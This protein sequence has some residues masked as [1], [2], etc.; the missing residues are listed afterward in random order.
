MPYKAASPQM[1]FGLLVLQRVKNQKLGI[2]SSHQR[3][4]R[5]HPTEEIQDTKVKLINWGLI[6]IL[7]KSTYCKSNNTIY[8]QAMLFWSL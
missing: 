1:A 5:E 6:V 2:V 4:D 8:V 3:H 7:V